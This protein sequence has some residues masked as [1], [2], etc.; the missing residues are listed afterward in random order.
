MGGKKKLDSLKYGLLD[1]SLFFC[2]LLVVFPEAWERRS[3]Q[4]EYFNK[5]KIAFSQRSGCQMKLSGE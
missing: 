5:I 4:S 3:A 1:V 2:K